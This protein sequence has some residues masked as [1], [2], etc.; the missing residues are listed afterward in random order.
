MAPAADN[1]ISNRDNRSHRPHPLPLHGPGRQEGKIV[2]EGAR[3]AKCREGRRSK[4]R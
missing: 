3:R 1:F 4:E 2:R